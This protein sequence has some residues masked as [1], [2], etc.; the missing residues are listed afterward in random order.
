ME[1]SNRLKAIANEVQYPFVADI[2]TDHAYVL[3]DLFLQNKIQ[4]AIA[5]DIKEGPLKKAKENITYFG[6]SDKIQARKGNGMSVLEPKE[7]DTAIIAG[8]G[9]MLIIDIL[10]QSMEVVKNLKELIIQ[11]QLDIDSVRKHLHQIGF[12]IENE[13]MILEEEKFYTI[14]RAVQGKEIYEKEEQYLY[15]KI[16]LDRKDNILKQYLYALLQKQHKIKQQLSLSHTQN[17]KDKLE[18][19]KQEKNKLEEVYKCL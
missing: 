8:M 10:K 16:L 15:G 17:A 11:P 7:V 13:V 5:C 1:L 4:K 6:F 2:G 9:G 3:I 19:L 14:I 12:K 18:E